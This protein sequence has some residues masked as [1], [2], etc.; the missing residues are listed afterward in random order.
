MAAFLLVLAMIALGVPAQASATR[1]VDLAVVAEAPVADDAGTDALRSLESA[2]PAADQERPRRV[3]SISTGEYSPYTSESATHGGFIN[4]VIRA[5]FALRGMDTRFT[6][7][8][9]KRALEE[10][11]AGAFDASSFWF[12]DK[13]RAQRFH[14]S[15]SLSSHR[16][17][18]FHL[19]SREVPDWK[20]LDDLRGFTFG[21]TLGYTYTHAFWEAAR[22]GRIV[23]HE[24]RADELNFK[25]LLAGRIDLFPMEE[26]TGWQL[27]RKRL[28]VGEGVLTT[29]PRPLSS[30]TGHLVFPRHLAG[31][32]EL[33]KIFNQGLR[34]LR[35]SGLYEQYLEEFYAGIY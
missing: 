4:R 32:A 2:T 19:K 21:A 17:V 35:D 24:A 15:D 16:E 22:S 18:L 31:N 1:P 11:A 29:H 27:I 28:P 7:F 34:Q 30:T 12:I 13:E 25:K 14:Y 9:W 10:A 3:V 5:A 20:T 6:Y 33:V 23:V 8:P 26:I